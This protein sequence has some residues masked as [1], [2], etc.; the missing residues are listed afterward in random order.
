[1]T[2]MESEQAALFVRLKLTLAAPLALA[3][4]L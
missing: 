4:T 3:A 1:M 2:V